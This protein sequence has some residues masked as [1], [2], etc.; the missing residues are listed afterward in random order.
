MPT[1]VI[2][3]QMGE[4]IFEGTITKWLKKPGEAVR[5]DEPL[6]EISTDKVDAEIPSPASGVLHD[7]KVQEGATVQVNTVVATIDADG[8]GTATSAPKTSTGGSPSSTATGGPPLSSP[9][10]ARQGGNVRLSR[11]EVPSS[12][13]AQPARQGGEVPQPA[14]AVTDVIMPQM[15]ESIFE[16]TIT[17]WL[18]KPGDRVQRDEPLFEIST[19]KVD[20]EIPSPTAGVLHEIKVD[21]GATVQ[22]NTV[23]ATIAAT[24]AAAPQAG[25]PRLPEVGRRGSEKTEVAPRSSPPETPAPV[26]AQPAVAHPCHARVWRD[27][28]GK[29]KPTSTTSALPLSSAASPKSTA[30]ISAWSPVP[31][32]AAASPRKISSPSSIARRPRAPPPPAAQLCRARFPRVAHPCRRRCDR[33]GNLQSPPPPSPDK[34]SPCLPCARKSP[35][36]WSSPSASALTSTACTKWT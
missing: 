1:D 2:M 33:V 3:P 29:S 30:W 11:P 5:R 9:N 8:A 22:V 4:S 26:S 7:I 24:G 15:G 25:A 23:V 10:L 34:S 19:D 31:D 16:G 6:F 36:A 21:Q 13:S 27:R 32:R 12:T 28:V 17:K 18:K 14:G 20:A 35:S